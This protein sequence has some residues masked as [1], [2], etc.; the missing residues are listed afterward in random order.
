[1]EKLTSPTYEQ[2]KPFLTP[3]WRR[4]ALSFP[5]RIHISPHPTPDT[6]NTKAHNALLNRIKHSPQS[7]IAYSDGSHT[8]HHGFPRTG[9]AMVMYH[10]DRET[11]TQQ[12]GLGGNAEIYDAEMAGLMMAA[13]ATCKRAKRRNNINHIFLFADN[14]SAINSIFDPKPGPGQIYAI[15]AHHHLTR[16]LDSHPDNQVTIMWCPSHQKIRG[17]ER[18]DRLAKQATNRACESP[19]S[20][21]IARAR[22]K[23]K[24]ATGIAWR[25]EWRTSPKLGGYATANRIPPSTSPSKAFCKTPR[26]VFGRLIQCRTNHSYT[27]EFRRRFFPQEDLSCPCGEEFQTRE[28]II[29]HCIRKMGMSFR[30][31]VTLFHSL[32]C[33][34]LPYVALN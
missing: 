17:N 6:D 24:A 29:V 8:H 15:K 27:G 10:E 5:N 12:M 22:R 9:A 3:P 7:V 11:K 28:H 31:F 33:L 19:V 14:S 1:L 21:T 2:T 13:T 25:K 16:F 18:A 32:C 4:S 26:E 30:T 20:H 34:M 23:T